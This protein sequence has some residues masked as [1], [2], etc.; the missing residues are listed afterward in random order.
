MPFLKFHRIDERIQT[1]QSAGKWLEKGIQ[2]SQVPWWLNTTNQPL[3]N[4]WSHVTPINIRKVQIWNSESF[5]PR[6]SKGVK[7]QPAFQTSPSEP[8]KWPC[9]FPLHWLFNMNPYN[10]LLESPHNCVVSSLIYPKQPAVFSLFIWKESCLHSLPPFE[11]WSCLSCHAT[12][13]NMGWTTW[14]PGNGGK[15]HEHHNYHVI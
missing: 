10:G 5:P 3:K 1:P 13:K 14:D 11:S 7:F 8:R 4:C 9:Y 6:P 15:K 12:G 2:I